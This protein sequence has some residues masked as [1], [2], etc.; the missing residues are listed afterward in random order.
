M[1][2]IE[3]TL[4]AEITRLSRRETRQLISKAISELRRLRQ[5]LAGVERELQAIKAARAKEKATI[6]IKAVREPVLGEQ[7]VRMSPRLIRAVRNRLGIS[8]A[9]LAKLVGVSTLAVGNWELG[10]T[11]PRPESKARIAALRKL[12]RREARRLLAE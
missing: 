8:Q 11:K 6:K 12:G 7:T 3:T 2:K 10:K 1:G 9:K 4:K 5:R